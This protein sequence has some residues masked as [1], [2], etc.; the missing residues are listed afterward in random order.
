MALETNVT[1]EQ[2]LQTWLARLNDLIDLVE[3]TARDGDWSTRRIEKRLK[4]SRLGSYVAPVLIMQHETTR[5]LMEP[6][7]S[8]APGAEGVV[9]LYLM[10]AY[11]DLASIY[12]HD[13]QWW[14]HYFPQGE[15][16]PSVRGAG[17]DAGQVAVGMRDAPAQPLSEGSLRHVLAEMREHAA[18]LS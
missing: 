10:P 9:D 14:L 3:R 6:I 8:S 7:A 2:P 11:D 12:F 4:D 13:G 16:I 15:P 1:L 5:V 18:A 17:D